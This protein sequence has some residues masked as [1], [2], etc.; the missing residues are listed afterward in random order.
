MRIVRIGNKACDRD[1]RIAQKPRVVFGVLASDSSTE[2]GVV[3]DGE[4]NVDDHAPAMADTVQV[5]PER[6]VR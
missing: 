2:A 3:S 1:A 5:G 4:L 6:S